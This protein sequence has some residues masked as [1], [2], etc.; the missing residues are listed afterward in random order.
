MNV[1]IMESDPARLRDLAR[2]WGVPDKLAP[3]RIVQRLEAAYRR[4]VE[5]EERRAMHQRAL[6]RHAERAA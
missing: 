2:D 4:E 6:R 1:R 3:C 5:E